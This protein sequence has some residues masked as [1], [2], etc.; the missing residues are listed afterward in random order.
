MGSTEKVTP[1]V[2]RYIKTHMQSE[3]HLKGRS[4][5]HDLTIND[6]NYDELNHLDEYTNL[7]SLYCNEGTIDDSLPELVRVFGQNNDHFIIETR[8]PERGVSIV[9]I[10]RSNATDD[11][12]RF[13]H[14]SY[15]P[16]F[17]NCG[18]DNSTRHSTHYVDDYVVESYCRSKYTAYMGE[19]ATDVYCRHE[20]TRQLEKN[21]LK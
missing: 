1:L 16:L 17:N 12:E 15:F 9:H 19:S 3:Q 20:F 18:S 8:D 13:N 14:N 6:D 21:P 5:I 4:T 7:R 2:E 10:W 11:I